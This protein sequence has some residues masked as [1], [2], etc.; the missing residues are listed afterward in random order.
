MKLLKTKTAAYMLAE[1]LTKVT[2]WPV[3]KLTDMV[4]GRY[5]DTKAKLEI[6]WIKKNLDNMTAQEKFDATVQY[7]SELAWV[8]DPIIES[9]TTVLHAVRNGQ[10]KSLIQRFEIAYSFLR[11][12]GVEKFTPAVDAYYM[13]NINKVTV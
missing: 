11:S 12:S 8:N 2:I 1:G 4:S 5:T 3:L 13:L 10:D 9:S 7:R 6:N